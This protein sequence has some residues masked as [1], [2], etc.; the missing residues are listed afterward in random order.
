[1]SVSWG[2]HLQAQEVNRHVNLI[3]KVTA[4]TAVKVK[5]FQKPIL[6]TEIRRPPHQPSLCLLFSGEVRSLVL[7]IQEDGKVRGD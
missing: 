4:R 7:N 2:S 5:Y 6:C 1:M 3:L